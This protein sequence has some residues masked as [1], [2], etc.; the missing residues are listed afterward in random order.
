M[1]LINFSILILI[2]FARCSTNSSNVSDTNTQTSI[3]LPTHNFNETNESDYSKFLIQADSIHQQCLDKGDDML[4]CS[5]KY[6]SEM[7]SMLNV[8]YKNLVKD[9]DSATKATL[10]KEEL[11]WLRQRDKAFSDF[12]NEQV[13]EISAYDNQTLSLNKKAEFVKERV[14]K[15]L[16][17]NR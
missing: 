4:A 1:R 14:V 2:F 3:H 9:A 12:D 7:D 13:S 15:L 8:V 6:Y 17:R 5:Q 10:K 16:T 11:E